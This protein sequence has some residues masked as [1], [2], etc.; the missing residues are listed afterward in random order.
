MNS[1]HR[2]IYRLAGL[3]MA[4]TFAGVGLVF[5]FLPERVLVFFNRL[6]P[7]GFSPAPVQPG[8]FFPILAVAYMVLVTG[9]AWQMYRK[10]GNPVFPLL[11]AQGKLASSILSL[12][13][14]FT[15]APYLVCL[16][17]AVVDGAI[18]GLVLWLHSLQ[19]KHSGSWP[20]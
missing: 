4:A 11:L 14:F 19:K 18:G 9:L 6:S 20:T 12:Y 15:R 10:P 13:F 8:S 5:L 2:G 16:A 3:A 1:R 7:P 17:N